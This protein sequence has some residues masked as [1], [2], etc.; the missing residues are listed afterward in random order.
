MTYQ[1]FSRIRYSRIKLF[2]IFERNLKYVYLPITYKNDGTEVPRR[3]RVIIDQFDK[4][5]P[6]KLNENEI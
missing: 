1:G 4:K 6:K 2:F 5:E 3:F